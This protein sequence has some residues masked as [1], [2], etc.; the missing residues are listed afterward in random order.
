[1]KIHYFRHDPCDELG[2]IQDWA[3]RN[4]LPLTSTLFY[5]SSALPDVKEIDFLIIM[6]GP[7][8]VYDEKSFPWLIQEKKFIREA[9]KLNKKVLG[10]CLGAQLIADVLGAKV[11][12]NK[13]KEIGWF[14]VH[15]NSSIKETNILDFIPEILDVFHW[16]G[17]TYDLPVGAKHLA[18]SEACHN[19]AFIYNDKVL[20]LQFHFEA[21]ESSITNMIIYGSDELKK[22]DY[23]QSA[24]EIKLNCSMIGKNNEIM[25]KILDRM[26][27]L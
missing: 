1:M 5:E 6:G 16:H 24:E 12:P 8:G 2:I 17:D 22:S 14:P 7:M 15:F 27:R 9:L 18:Y 21:T 19:Q 11:Y 20:G 4:K 3:V 26:I 25:M 10:I 13:F 23:V